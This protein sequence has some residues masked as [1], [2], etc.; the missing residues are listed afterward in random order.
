[1]IDELRQTRNFVLFILFNKQLFSAVWTNIFL[2]LFATYIVQLRF[3]VVT[4]V[5][6]WFL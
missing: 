1:M 2:K 3:D 5:I 4:F 6:K